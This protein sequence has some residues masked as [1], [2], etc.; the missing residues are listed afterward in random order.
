MKLYSVPLKIDAMYLRGNG[1]QSS[2]G[3]SLTVGQFLTT[4]TYFGCF[5][6]E[7]YAAHTSITV[8]RAC[9]TAKGKGKMEIFHYD[10]GRD[11]LVRE[12]AFHTESR[13]RVSLLA[14]LSTYKTGILYIRITGEAEIASISYEAEG[15]YRE[16]A[17]A[18]LLCTYKREEFIRNNLRTA[19]VFLQSDSFL[20]SHMDIFCIDNGGTLTSVP[21]GVSLLR[22]RNLGGSGGYAR[23]MLAAEDARR[24]THFWLM[25]DDIRF[26][27]EIISRVVSFLCFRK[28]DDFRLA[29]GM[30]TFE[31]PSVQQEATAEFTGYTFRSNASG[32]DFRKRESLL[33]NRIA[34]TAFTYGGWWSL[35]VP[36]ADGLPMPFFIKLDDVEYGLRS[37]GNYVVMNGFGVWH[38]AFGKKAN[39]WAEYYTARN[40]LII[41]S[42]FPACPH[43]AI[44]TMGVRLLKA[45]AFNEPKCMEAVCKGVEDFLRGPEAFRTVDPEKRHIQLLEQ[46]NV[47]LPSSI[48][49]RNML[50]SAALNILKPRNWKSVQLFLKSIRLLDSSGM[51]GEWS[52]LRTENF[53]RTAL[54]LEST[55]DK[56]AEQNEYDR[57]GYQRS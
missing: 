20:A 47:S 43:S 14:S 8:I 50:S 31:E 7:A 49:R 39:A 16:T 57:G 11:L 56:H 35:I 41:Q 29:A 19:S 18:L 32:F 36:V 48:T 3:V 46:F 22:N 55:G 26:E 37:S 5:P 33:R 52:I 17:I 44:K 13:A 51:T 53:W 38:E 54:R 1:R 2:E 15:E 21:A 24:Y 27:P 30:F 23:G 4:D 40:T 12:C 42:L 9:I 6:C 34:A 28:S 10:D 45:L 25:D